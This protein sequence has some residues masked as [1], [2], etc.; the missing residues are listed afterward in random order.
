[1]TKKE[2]IEE[3]KIFAYA[4]MLLRTLATINA[5]Y[6]YDERGRAGALGTVT[7]YLIAAYRFCLCFMFIPYSH[8]IV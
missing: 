2:S 5:Y 3:S 1:M 6:V 7:P 4:R 8:L